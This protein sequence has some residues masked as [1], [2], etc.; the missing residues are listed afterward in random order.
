VDPAA[1]R[2]RLRARI[3]ELIA[4]DDLDCNQPN[5]RHDAETLLRHHWPEGVLTLK[6]DG[7]TS[8]QLGQILAAVRRVEAEVGAPFHPDDSPPPQSRAAAQRALAAWGDD[9]NGAWMAASL[10]ATFE[11]CRLPDCTLDGLVGQF[12]IEQCERLYQA[13]PS[14]E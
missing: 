1:D 2:D 7:H 9:I 12:S 8:E 11:Q 5:C 4:D 14:T 3:A 13:A 6:H 10:I